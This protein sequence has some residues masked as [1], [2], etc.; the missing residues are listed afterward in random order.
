MVHS[1]YIF[2]LCNFHCKLPSI[3]ETGMHKMDK[4]VNVLNIHVAVGIMDILPDD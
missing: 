4:K 1:T 2:P 3:L